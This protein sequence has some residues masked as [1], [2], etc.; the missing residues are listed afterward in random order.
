MK[1]RLFA[2][3]SMLVVFAS[4]VPAG[5]MAAGS[6]EDPD[7]LLFYLPLVQLAYKYPADYRIYIPA[8]TFQMGC[9]LLHNAGYPCPADELPLHTVYLS[10]YYI[11]THEVTN[12]QYAQCVAFGACTPPLDSTSI[13]RPSYYGNPDYADYPVIWVVWYQAE[14]Y[15]TWVGGSLPTEAQWEKAARGS[16]DTRTFP[17]GDGSPDCTLANINGD[18]V[19]DTSAVG[20]YPS[21]ASPYGALDMAGN[22]WEWVNDWYSDTYYSISPA[23]NPTGPT[24]GEIKI[25]RGGCLSDHEWYQRVTIRNIFTP[26]FENFNVGFRCA[27]LPYR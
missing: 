17:W 4:I 3:L 16:S 9:D 26:T 25:L 22:V 5:G 23:S 27:T 20:S 1:H 18:C 11:D 13:T 10:A 24:S 14:D 8:G 2:L 21:G 19:G 15:C 6:K 12:A 7:T